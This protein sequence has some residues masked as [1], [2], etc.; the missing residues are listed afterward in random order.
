MSPQVIFSSKYNRKRLSAKAI[1]SHIMES[2]YLSRLFSEAYFRL[3]GLPG[4]PW[5]SEAE[6]VQNWTDC[7]QAGNASVSR[8]PVIIKLASWEERGRIEVFRILEALTPLGAYPAPVDIA[9]KRFKQVVLKGGLEDSHNSIIDSEE[10][11]LALGNSL[12]AALLSPGGSGEH[13][14]DIPMADF[15]L[16]YTEIVDLT[17]D[18]SIQSFTGE[19]QDITETGTFDNLSLESS[20]QS[21]PDFGP[22]FAAPTEDYV[23]SSILESLIRLKKGARG[24]STSVEHPKKEY[25]R[26]QHVR[27]L[28]KSI[29]QIRTGKIPGASIHKVNRSKASQMHTWDEMKNY[30]LRN[31]EELDTL[32]ETTSGPM[33]DGRS[34]REEGSVNVNAARSYNDNFISYFFSFDSIRI[35]NGLFADLVYD[36]TPEEICTKMKKTRCCKGPHTE[37]CEGIWRKVRDYA[38]KGMW[39]ELERT[40]LPE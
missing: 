18:P 37:E 15:R 24:S 11:E 36:C 17:D 34:R 26:C 14:I 28:K 38:K 40:R 4:F 6:F 30:Y 35:Y 39:K 20:A 22:T 33:T 9:V 2:Q 25:F 12:G 13:M 5:A 16:P 31:K 7:F 27:A 19:L 29:R 1:P 8:L 23:S 3:Y 32:A 21:N 10:L